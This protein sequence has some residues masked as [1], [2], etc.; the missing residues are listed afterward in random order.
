MGNDRGD[1][2][3]TPFGDFY[4]HHEIVHEITIACSPQS[5]AIAEQKKCTLKEIMNA[6]LL[7][8]GL[9]KI[10]GKTILTSNCLLNKVTRK[11]E[12]MTP[13]KL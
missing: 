1:E 3:E 7:S 9:P 11:K 8:S 12:D 10:C 2:Y 13:Y 5:N 4:A 6:M